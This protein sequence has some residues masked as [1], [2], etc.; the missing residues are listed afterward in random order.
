MNQ[1]IQFKLYYRHDYNGTQ[2]IAEWEENGK[3]QREVFYSD[4]PTVFGIPKE[5]TTIAG[6][7]IPTEA[8]NNALDNDKVLVYTYNPQTGDIAKVDTQP[9]INTWSTPQGIANQMEH[10]IAECNCDGCREARGEL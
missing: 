2:S 5:I 4:N 9:P 6:H 3:T 10:D 7:Q 1:P 8:L